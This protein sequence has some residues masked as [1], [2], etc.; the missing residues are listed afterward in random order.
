MPERTIANPRIIEGVV[1]APKAWH[2]PEVAD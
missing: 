1:P 2:G